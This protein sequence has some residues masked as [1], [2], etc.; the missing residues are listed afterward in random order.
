MLREYAKQICCSTKIDALFE[1]R[2]IQGREHGLLLQRMQKNL[3]GCVSDTQSK[4]GET[5]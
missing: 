5:K 1:N 2:A 3:F 4:N